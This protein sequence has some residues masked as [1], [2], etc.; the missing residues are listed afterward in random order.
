[1]EDICVPFWERKNQ[2]TGPYH[3]Y[4]DTDLSILSMK[5]F[6]QTEA[7]NKGVLGINTD[8]ESK[9]HKKILKLQENNFCGWELPFIVQ[10]AKGAQEDSDLC[11]QGQTKQYVVRAGV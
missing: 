3:I 1:M 8:T 6:I 4:Y 9:Q 2:K 7:G 11:L 5:V 10:L